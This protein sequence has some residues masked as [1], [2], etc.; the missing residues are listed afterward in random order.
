MTLECSRLKVESDGRCTCCPPTGFV[1]CKSDILVP[2]IDEILSEIENSTSP[3]KRGSKCLS[4]KESQEQNLNDVRKKIRDQEVVL[5]LGAGISVSMGMP[6]WKGLISKLTGYA[7]QY[8][9]WANPGSWDDASDCESARQKRA[10]ILMLEK[11]LIEGNLYLLNDINTLEAAQYVKGTLEGSWEEQATVLIKSIIS[12]IIEKSTRPE[13]YFRERGIACTDVSEDT[14]KEMAATNSLC[15]VAYMLQAK[16]GFRKVITYNYD[17]LL[18]EFLLSPVFGVTKDHIV[19]HS[20]KWTSQGENE[21][22]IEIFHVHGCIPR[23]ENQGKLPSFPPESQQIILSEDSYYETEQREAYNWLNS[24]QSYFLNKNTCIFVGFSADDYNFRR[25]LRQQGFKQDS[26]SNSHSPSHYL[27]L[28]VD[29]LVK[30]T[31]ESVCQ[32]HMSAKGAQTTT[33]DLQMEAIALVARE[34]EMKEQYWSRYN[35]HPI[36][37]TKR[38]VPSVLLSLL[39][40]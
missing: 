21:D 22:I 2:P 14:K 28:T 1:C 20:E 25:I 29:D 34:M 8:R 7:F 6:T 24:I 10:R 16:G 9:D 15:A 37:T 18:Q 30:N 17:T 38:D 5:A 31:W 26:I 13:D 36:W 27:I 40:S 32:Y 11:E 23:K 3:S 19:T 4:Q 35:F 39:N 33:A 12:A